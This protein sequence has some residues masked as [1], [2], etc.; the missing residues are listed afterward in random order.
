MRPAQSW[1]AQPCRPTLRPPELAVDVAPLQHCPHQKVSGGDPEPGDRR[2]RV[3]GLPQ[4]PRAVVGERPGHRQPD[5]QRPERG[6]GNGARV[7]PEG[8][9]YP[10]ALPEAMRLPTASMAATVLALFRRKAPS[11]AQVPGPAVLPR[12]DLVGERALCRPCGP[13]TRH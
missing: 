7:P 2:P 12:G 11:A 1:G 6:G 4:G 3:S 8:F 9:I 13:V 5:D 10:K